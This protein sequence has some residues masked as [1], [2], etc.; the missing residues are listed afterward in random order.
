MPSP[1]K[2]EQKKAGAAGQNQSVPAFLCKKSHLTNNIICYIVY[3]SAVLYI[4]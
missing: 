3:P 1:D 4:V 2:D